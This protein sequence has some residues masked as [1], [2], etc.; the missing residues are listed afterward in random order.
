MVYRHLRVRVIHKMERYSESRGRWVGIM[1]FIILG[2]HHARY[3]D[4]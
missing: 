1:A 4:E 2:G 3:R